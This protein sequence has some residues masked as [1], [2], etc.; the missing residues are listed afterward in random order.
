MIQRKFIPLILYC[1]DQRTVSESF[2]RQNLQVEEGA[3]FRES[4]IDK[5]IRNLMDSGT[6][7][8]VK[9]YLDPDLENDEKVALVFKV[10]TRARVGEISFN[11]NDKI[12][13]KK[14]SKSISTKL[15]KCLTFQR[16]MLT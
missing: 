13:D 9:V 3:I 7:Q 14:L 16:S 8:D 1:K 2:I 15:V 12:S 10:K 4:S 11:G 6:I 5:S